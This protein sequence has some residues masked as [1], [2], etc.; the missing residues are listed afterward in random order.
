MPHKVRIALDAMGGDHGASVIVAGAELSLARHPDS[1][2]AIFGDEALIAPLLAARPKLA[3]VT[4]LVHT[5]VAIKMDDKPS[6]ALRYGRVKSSMAKAIDAVKKGEAD[7][8][9]S[10]GNTGALMAMSRFNLKTMAGIDRPAIA[11][12]WPTLRGESIVLDVGAS[13]G[14]DAMHLVDLAVMG[15]AMARVLFDIERPTVGLLNIGVEEVKGLE[16]VRE[17]G[18]ILRERDLPDLA[19]HG[20]VEGDDIGKGTVDVVVTEGFAG[21]IALKSAEGTAR[22]IGQYLRSAMSRTLSA[23]IGY[24]FARQ[25]FRTLREK[26]DPRRSNGG[27]F[28]GLNGIVIK[29]HGG[30]DAEG[31]A[32]AIDLGYDMVRYEL[33]AKI[34]RALGEIQRGAP[35]SP[36]AAP[37]VPATEDT[38][39]E[40]SA[41]L[42]STT[43]AIGGAVS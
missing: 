34:S 25:A 13:I 16:E 7:V 23:R 36:A 12:L 17:A 20:F 29:S 21:N 42:I 8:A 32:A 22:Q 1:E 28:L 40:A 19:Y 41:S 37:Q 9:I 27:V 26:M 14:A 35:D 2:F 31:F 4:R 18:Q 11:A 5:D 15:S 6:Q 24:F 39:S 43:Q 30:A 33:L 38:V 10:A 3:A